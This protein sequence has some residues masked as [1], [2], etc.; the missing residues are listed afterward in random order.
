VLWA[1]GVQKKLLTLFGIALAV[2]LADQA[3][4]FWMV[5]ELTTRFE[6]LPTEGARLAAMYGQAP[7][8][9][10]DG[11]HFRPKRSFT[12]SP[13]YLRIRYAE[14]TG[15]A[16]G[17]FRGL[18][19]SLRGLLFHVVSLGAVVLITFYYLRL[20]SSAPEERLA[21]LGLALVLGGAIG[22]YV[23]RLARGFVVDFIEA[24]WHDRAYWPSFNLADSCIVVGVGLLLL[25]GLTRRAAKAEEVSPGG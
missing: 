5:G 13:G 1:G 6:G 16:F 21:R 18:P 11:L 9:G 17:L 20:S 10:F 15:A 12:L 19:P 4:K 2:V 23:D 14:N 7:P 25:D 8:E 24:H 22:N 3:V